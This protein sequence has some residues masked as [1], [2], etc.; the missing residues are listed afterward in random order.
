[1][2]YDQKI[3]FAQGAVAT[4]LGR[5]IR[6]SLEPGGRRGQVLELQY[7]LCVG[8][9]VPQHGLVL[10]GLEISGK[11][12]DRALEPHRHLEIRVHRQC[13]LRRVVL[14]R[15]EADYPGGLLAVFL[16]IKPVEQPG[17]IRVGGVDRGVF[18][19]RGPVI[20]RGAFGDRLLDR[21]HQDVMEDLRAPRD[22]VEHRGGAVG[23]DHPVSERRKLGFPDLV[24]V[25][26]TA[27][28][29]G[30]GVPVIHLQIDQEHP[31]DVAT[32]SAFKRRRDSNLDPAGLTVTG[33]GLITGE[34]DPPWFWQQQGSE[35]VGHY[36]D[37]PATR[38]R[39]VARFV[40]LLDV[41]RV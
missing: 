17:V 27:D 23:H 24:Q 13:L 41:E 3:G 11:R 1:M 12:D 16:G 28:H 15:V 40:S 34:T 35:F 2:A 39:P 19:E 33:R 9:Y 32:E 22:H 30:V 29:V 31:L 20:R 25:P 7:L 8:S 38:F 5:R 26:F 18:P 36:H 4:F 14:V 6:V 10:L 21:G 37:G